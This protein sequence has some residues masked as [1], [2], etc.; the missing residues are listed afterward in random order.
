MSPRWLPA[1]IPFSLAEL[2]P[3]EMADIFCIFYILNVSRSII[4][5][6]CYQNV[7]SYDM[8][9]VSFLPI[10]FTSKRQNKTHVVSLRLY[11]FVPKHQ[12]LNAPTPEF[13]AL[14]MSLPAALQARGWAIIFG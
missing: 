3:P 4:L 1:K 7:S 8:K 6:K 9:G 12:N 11:T 5:K 10:L 13:R 2:P 14:F